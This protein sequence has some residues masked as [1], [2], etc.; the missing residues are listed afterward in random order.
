VKPA[1]DANT[2]VPQFLSQVKELEY[3][4]AWA[5]DGTEQG[6]LG[7]VKES[8]FPE[9]STRSARDFEGYWLFPA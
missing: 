2:L 7:R 5:L 3:Q 6:E 4:F 9:S 8:R 1:D